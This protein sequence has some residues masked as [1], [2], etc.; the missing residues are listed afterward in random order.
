MMEQTQKNMKLVVLTH[1]YYGYE[2]GNLKDGLLNLKRYASAFIFN[3]N[4]HCQE[5]ELAVSLIKKDFP[6]AFILQTPNIGKDV[7]G[8]LAMIDLL[9]RTPLKPQYCILLHDKKSP[10]TPLGDTWRKKL[11]RIIEK[12]NIEAIIALLDKDKKIGIV[13]AK[14]F[15][16]NEYDKKKSEFNSTNGTILKEIIASYGFQLNAYDFVGGTMFWMRYEIIASFF[17]KHAA[18]RIRSNLEK[19]NVMDNVTGTKAHAWE[20]VLSWIATD[21]GY[22]IKGI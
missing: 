14:E 8:K 13:S 19:G 7:G 5:K 1:I 10:H 2:E 12:E 18:L 9:L 21:N 3:I 6:E 17:N 11:F 4:E 20:R 22:F 15:I 16:T